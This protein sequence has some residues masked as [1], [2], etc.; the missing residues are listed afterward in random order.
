MDGGA[1]DGDDVFE[2]DPGAAGA[3]VAGVAAAAGAG[4][5][6]AAGPGAAAIDADSVSDETGTSTWTAASRSSAVTRTLFTL[7]LKL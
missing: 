6:D 7:I 3:S 1:G 4:V 5:A 2:G